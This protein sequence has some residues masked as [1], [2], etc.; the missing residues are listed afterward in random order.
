VLVV[1]NKAEEFNAI[2]QKRKEGQI[3]IDLVRL[4]DKTSGGGY[5]GICW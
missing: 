2:E 1:G 5:Q 4:F 3:V